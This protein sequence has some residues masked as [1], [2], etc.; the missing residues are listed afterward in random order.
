MKNIILLFSIA[1]LAVSCSS[2]IEGEGAA[3]AK[4][5]FAVDHF[6]SLETHCNCEITL[7]PSDISKVVVESHQNLIDNMDIK[8]KGNDLVIKELKTVDNYDLYNVNVYFNPN[9]SEVEL[10]NQSKLKTSGTLKAD[11]F[12]FEINDQSS[13]TET[14]LDIKN[15]DLDVSDQ[16][17]IKMTGTAIN[18][19]INAYDESRTDL[20]E[21]Q[22]VEIDFHA[23]D[24]ASLSIYA[25]K[26][27]KGT[28]KDNAQVSYK[29]DPNKNTT[30][31]D[32][33]IIQKK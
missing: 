15:L 31:K 23:K 16:T 3:T 32:R 17:Q 24:N 18:V 8:T 20:T 12:S 14:F 13:I 9:L 25:M 33:A 4:K 6:T 22:A 1:T 30:E 11:Q 21:L 10:N 2:G 5:E 28:A 19:E 29:G 27:L 7:I 26:D